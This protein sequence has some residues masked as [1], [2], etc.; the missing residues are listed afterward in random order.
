MLSHSHY[1]T[2]LS[3]LTGQKSYKKGGHCSEGEIGCMDGWIDK[4]FFHVK[5]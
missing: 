1:S 3:S 5:K 4:A 2:T